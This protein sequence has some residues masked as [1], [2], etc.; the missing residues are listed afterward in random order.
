M[1]QVSVIILILL[2]NISFAQ[3]RNANW[4]FGDSAG[5]NFTIP[6]SPVL[7]NASLDTRGSCASISDSTGQLLFYANTRAGVF[8]KSGQVWNRNNVLMQDGDS[9]GGEGWYQEMI[10]IPNPASNSS[11]YLFSIGVLGT[12]PPGL[13]YSI[14]DMNQDSGMGS[15][16][17]KNIMLNSQYAV[18]GINGIK[19]ANGR[20]WWLLYR[21]S[22]TTYNNNFHA[23]LIT[24]DSIQLYS[25]QSVGDIPYT[26]AS[27]IQFNQTGD[28]ILVVS[29][30][31]LIELLDFDRCTGALTLNKVIE[32]EAVDYPYYFGCEFSPNG[33]F[34][35]VAS[36]DYNNGLSNNS[37]LYQ[38]DLNL[39]DPAPF[40]TTLY[41]FTLPESPGELKLAPDDKIY[42]SSG[43]QNWVSGYPYPDSIRNYIA[44]NL[45]VINSPD[46]LSTTCNFTPF[47]FY[48]GGKRTYIGLPNNP[49]YD[50]PWIDN[51][52]CDSLPHPVNINEI[53]TKENSISISPNP[54]YNKL[55]FHPFN[56]S[57]DKILISIFNSVGE[58]VFEKE[59]TMLDHEI[60]VRALE[61]GVYFL[62]I[63]G[64]IIFATKKIVKL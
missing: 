46:L 53:A 41:T 50:L 20:D 12:S 36:E 23:Y 13:Y 57:S 43:Y 19:H 54:F 7:Y 11:F 60:D 8:G 28:Q 61:K 47:S 48:L 49:N 34:A 51:S 56:S 55:S 45:S 3:L 2:S 31:G 21:E 6:S 35:Y 33:R 27:F 42:L 64:K 39:I 52:P 1:K 62:R 22:D 16:T 14:I 38:Y 24:P 59:A 15:V 44:E 5:I 9:I 29:W 17:Q 25:L 63:K 58:K 30:K 10:I 18:D 26:N 4:C 40:R 32:H 37:H